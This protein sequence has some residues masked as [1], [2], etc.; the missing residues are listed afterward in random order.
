MSTGLP[1]PPPPSYEHAH[2]FNVFPD[3]LFLSDIDIDIEFGFSQSKLNINV[4]FQCRTEGEDW[5]G[6]AAACEASLLFKHKHLQS[7]LVIS[8]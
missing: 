2:K 8:T 1:R 7:G 6:Y 5:E 3:P 4:I